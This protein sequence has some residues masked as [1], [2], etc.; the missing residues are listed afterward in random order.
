MPTER[1]RRLEPWP[2]AL[3][4]ALAQGDGSANLANHQIAWQAD[5]ETAR[6]I[7]DGAPLVNRWHKKFVDRVL[8]GGP[9][10]TEAE[11]K[12][13]F[14]CFDTEDF[15]TGYKAFLAKEKPAFRGK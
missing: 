12:E 4:A 10:L 6:R 3:A 14:A 5:L 7:A 9:P 1:R 8:A 13:G 15:N 11:A 2:I